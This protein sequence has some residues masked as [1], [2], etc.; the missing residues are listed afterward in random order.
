MI[1]SCIDITSQK[2]IEEKLR[3]AKEQVLLSLSLSLMK[4]TH[5]HHQA[6]AASRVKTQFLAVMSH[7]IRTPLTGMGLCAV[8]CCAVRACVVLFVYVVLLLH[9]RDKSFTVLPFL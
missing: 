3:H 2:E 1:G 6:E 4:Y 8:L 5:H 9:E 7:E